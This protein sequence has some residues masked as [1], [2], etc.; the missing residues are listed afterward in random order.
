[1]PTV[2]AQ[3]EIQRRYKYLC[4]ILPKA[5]AS[6]PSPWAF[7]NAP[8]VRVTDLITNIRGWMLILMTLIASL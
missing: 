5:G 8:T 3:Q 4:V 7:K 1:M 2:G 6:T